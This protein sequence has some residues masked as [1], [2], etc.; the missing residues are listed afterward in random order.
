MFPT[1][2]SIQIY[3]CGYDCIY[4]CT[5]V[6]WDILKIG[7]CGGL[8]LAFYMTTIHWLMDTYK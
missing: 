6:C 5:H 2:N 3:G 4:I 1:K 8:T 7:N